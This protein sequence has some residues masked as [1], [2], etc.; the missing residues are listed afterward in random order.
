[1]RLVIQKVKEA[2][3]TDCGAPY[4][5]IGHGLMVLVGI[6][7]ADGKEDVE[8]L[9]SKL[10]KMRI[11]EDEAGVMNLDVMQTGGEIMLVSQ[12]TLHASTKKGNR[13]SYLRAAKEPISRPIYEAFVLRVEQLLGKSVATGVFG[14]DMTIELTNLGPTTIVIDSKLRE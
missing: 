5:Q 6:E 12:F 14:G 8:W 7:E 11:F 10:V 3:L 2:K 13:P 9:A 4:S 1:M